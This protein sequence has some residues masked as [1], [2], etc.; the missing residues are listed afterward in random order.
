MDFIPQSVNLEIDDLVITSGLE[1]SIPRGLQVGKIFEINK[2]SNELW[3]SAFV[4][5]LSNLNN[6]F[7][8]SVIIPDFEV[9]SHEN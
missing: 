6:I 1:G 4:D 7:I 9:E 2:E 3:Q 5:P 8:V